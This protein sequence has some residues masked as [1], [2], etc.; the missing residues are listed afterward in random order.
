MTGGV[1]EAVLLDRDGTINAKAPD[2]AY[3]TSP[4]G[5]MLL[6]GAAEAIFILNAAEVPVAVVTNQRGVALGLMTEEDLDRVHARLRELLC[7]AGAR[8]DGIFYC[9][10]E[11]HTCA[12]RKPGTLLLER[13]QHQLGLSSLGA[14]VMI[15][16]S[17]SDVIAGRAAG[18]RTV[19]LTASDGRASRADEVASSLLTAVSRVLGL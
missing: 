17:V 10:H 12:C 16:D 8:L 9:P 14:S 7:D 5:V 18:A 13:A 6:P 15:G 2:G 11:R 3:V 19:L 1:P 4:D